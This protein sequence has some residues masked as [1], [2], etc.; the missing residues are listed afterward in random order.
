MW[1]PGQL[2]QISERIPMNGTFVELSTTC[3]VVKNYSKRHRC[4][5]CPMQQKYCNIDTCET[6]LPTTCTLKKAQTDSEQCES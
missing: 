2:V 1:K 4:I 3:R 6:M 5:N